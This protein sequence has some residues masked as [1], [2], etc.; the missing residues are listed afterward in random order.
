MT[1]ALAARVRS[2]S[3]AFVAAFRYAASLIRVLV[4]ADTLAVRIEELGRSQQHLMP[5]G[6]R[7]LSR[8]CS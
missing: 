5:V 6:G 8:S 4:D 1:D 2:R 7:S 3:L